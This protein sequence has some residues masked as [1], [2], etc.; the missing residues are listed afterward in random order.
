MKVFNLT[1][2]LFIAALFTSGGALSGLGERE[3]PR[4][5]QAIAPSPQE[6]PRARDSLD[7]LIASLSS[8]DAAYTSGNTT[9]AR[10]RL[11]EANLSWNKISPAISSREAR[12][13][14]LLLNTLDAKLKSDASRAEV[15][16]TI[17]ILLE[18]LSEN[19]A[20]ELR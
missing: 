4:A 17:Y 1:N 19:I 5:E 14:R 16:S 3:W 9:E 7:Q 18:E 6:K 2:G 10:A 8:V 13:A 12:D 11:E 15:N 20:A